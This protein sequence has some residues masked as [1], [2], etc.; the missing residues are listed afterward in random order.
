MTSQWLD[1]LFNILEAVFII[2]VPFVA[3]GI[4]YRIGWRDAKEQGFVKTRVRHQNK[5]WY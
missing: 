4:G 2:L 5:L 1:V 3:M